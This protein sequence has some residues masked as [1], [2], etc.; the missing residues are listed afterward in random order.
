MTGKSLRGGVSPKYV[1]VMTRVGRIAL[2]WACMGLRAMSI[3]PI[4]AK[5]YF[6]AVFLVF[7]NYSEKC[8]RGVK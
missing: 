4:A 2:S 1:P 7:Q 8:R 5:R 6:M 3:E